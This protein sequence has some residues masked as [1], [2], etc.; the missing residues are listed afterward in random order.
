MLV[1]RRLREGS[2]EKFRPSARRGSNR[3]RSPMK[4]RSK[5]GASPAIAPA[6][7]WKPRA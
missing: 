2:V 7:R 1:P 6:N 4:K 5:Y 3:F